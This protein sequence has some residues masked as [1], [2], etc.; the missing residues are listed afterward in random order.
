M[1]QYLDF[2]KDF[3]STVDMSHWCIA[4]PEREWV[5]YVRVF[6]FA[7]LCLGI[8]I[9]SMNKI[10]Y[11]YHV[12]GAREHP[13]TTINMFYT[14]ITPKMMNKRGD[15]NMNEFLFQLGLTAKDLKRATDGCEDV[16]SWDM[17]LNTFQAMHTL[18]MKE[19]RVRP[20]DNMWMFTGSFT[21]A[22][23]HSPN[24][25]TVEALV[26][27]FMPQRLYEYGETEQAWVCDSMLKN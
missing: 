24:S 22:M 14:E 3:D 11:D 17:H 5:E 23:K 4:E 6:E 25:Y 7:L 26:S 16:S 18:W 2:I 19:M 8:L 1:Y 12:D 20:I 15:V 9:M 13:P 21:Q 27:L 10:E